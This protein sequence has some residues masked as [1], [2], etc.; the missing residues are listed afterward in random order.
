MTDPSLIIFLAT[1]SLAGILGAVIAYSGFCTFGAIA[2]WVSFSDKGRLGAWLLAIGVSISGVSLLESLSLISIA[3]SVI[4]YTST[5]FNPLRYLGGG[6]LF[7]IGMHLSGG[8]SSKALVRLGG[9]S[10]Q[11]LTICCFAAMMSYALIY[12]SLYEN[13]FHPFLT[14]FSMDL[15]N[16]GGSSQRL[17]DLLKIITVSAGKHYPQI[18]LGF[19]VSG[20]SL[21]LISKSTRTAL[22]ISGLLVGMIVVSGWYLTGGPLGAAWVEHMSFEWQPPRNLGIQSFT[23]ISPLADVIGVFAN[24]EPQRSVTFGL[25]SVVGVCFGSF[26]YHLACRKL[27]LNR[28][29]SVRDFFRAACGGILLGVG[30]VLALGCSIGQGVTGFSTLAIGSILASFSMCFGAALA[31]KIEFYRLM[32][33]TQASWLRA[34]VA[35]LADF[36]LLPKSMRKLDVI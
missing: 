15:E 29:K 32:Y 31:L 17:N 36:H 13:I 24:S 11:A 6:L 2:D 9:G 27:R 14:P 7:G 10:I 28:F 23:F 30:G 16:I 1:F 35:T 18:L 5:T 20:Y 4:P 25:V 34:V 26:I 3:D 19:I 33:P 22:V 21:Y 8:C 12:T